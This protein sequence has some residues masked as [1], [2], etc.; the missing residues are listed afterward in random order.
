MQQC[1]STNKCELCMIDTLCHLWI[2]NFVQSTEEEIP[3]CDMF[4]FVDKDQWGNLETGGSGVSH[5]GPKCCY[6]HVVF[7]EIWQN[8]ML[9]PIRPLLRGRRPLGKSWIRPCLEL[10]FHQ[11]NLL[12]SF[13]T[14]Q[15]FN[16]TNLTSCNGFWN[17]S[18]SF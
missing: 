13:Q 1:C 15:K 12:F 6:F 10:H 18:E 14:R 16:L 17:H 5:E 8:C 3:G 11:S 9:A 2:Y 7:W 4:C